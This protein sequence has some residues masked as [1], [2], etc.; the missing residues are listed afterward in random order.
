MSEHPQIGA[1]AVLGQLDAPEGEEPAPPQVEGGKLN[2]LG[3]GAVGRAA[4]PARV[5]GALN[6]AILPMPPVR[7]SHMSINRR[8]EELTG[9]VACSGRQ[10]SLR[11]TSCRATRSR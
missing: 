2:A 4:H 1:G 5:V 8:R 11:W 9:L 7:H 3:R 6:H 10:T